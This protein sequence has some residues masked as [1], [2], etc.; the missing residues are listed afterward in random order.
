[1]PG[2]RLRINVTD[3]GPGIRPE[4]L[5]LL[6]TP[7]ERLAAERP[8]SRAPAS[9]WPCPSGW[10]RPW[11]ARSSVSTPGQ[12]STFWSSCRWS[13]ARSSGTSGQLDTQRRSAAEPVA[14]TGADLTVLYIE[15]NLSNLRLVERILGH[16]PGV[17]LIS[18][19]QG[20]S[21]SSWPAS[22]TP[23]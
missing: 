17:R 7:F 6:F 22:T 15:D 12:G 14:Q 2:D 3:T 9:A 5:D 16:R 19:M 13:R 1:M 4:D 8:A 21:A 20:R 11:A 10:P 18:A 23:T